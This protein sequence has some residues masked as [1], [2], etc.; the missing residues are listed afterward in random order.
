MLEKAKHLLALEIAEG[1]V[2]LNLGLVTHL[3]YPD[4]FFDRI[5]HCDTYYYWDNFV[6]ANAELKRILKP[7]GLMVITLSFDELKSM[8]REG[9][10]EKVNCDPIDYM[11]SLEI[12]G[13][14]NVRVEYV[15][16]S[17][18][19][20]YQGIF[21]IKPQE[22]QI[23]D[24]LFEMQEEQLRRS[25]SAFYAQEAMKRSGRNVAADYD[26]LSAK[27]SK[28]SSSSSS[29]SSSNS[30]IDSSTSNSQTVLASTK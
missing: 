8:H 12:V 20:P 11:H 6:L 2:H 15:E 22:E 5:F 17:G 4:S 10:L 7:D 3:P 26:P 1:K 9:L 16:R 13:F 21:A 18:E 19:K 23:S 24:E 14:E 27:E 30:A 25:I 29:S 28:S